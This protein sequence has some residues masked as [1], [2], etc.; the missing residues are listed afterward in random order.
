MDYLKYSNDG[1]RVIGVSSRFLTYVEIPN[2]VTEIGSFA[3][4]GCKSLK[5]VIIPNSVTKIGSYSFDGCESLKSIK[6]PDSVTTIE[7]SAFSGCNNIESV[8]IP[9]S[10]TKIGY[11]AFGYCHRLYNIEI[12][13]SVREIGEYAFDNCQK[14]GAIYINDILFKIKGCCPETVIIQE[15]T[16]IISDGAFANCTTLQNV[17]IPNS[18]EKIGNEAFKGCKSLKSIILPDNIKKIGTYAFNDCTSLKEIVFPESVCMEIGGNAFKNTE[19][20]NNQEDGA[21]YINDVLYRFKES[22]KE[23]ICVVKDGTK[24]I[25]PFAF[26]GCKD[27]QEIVIPDCVTDIGGY[28]FYNCSSLKK[29]FISNNIKR[30]DDYSFYNCTSLES[31]DI[32]NSVKS[33]GESA[34]SGCSSLKIIDIPN[35]IEEIGSKAFFNCTSLTSIDIPNSIKKVGQE[36]FDNTKW[37]NDYSDGVVYLN[38][39]LYTIK[40]GFEATQLTIKEGTTCIAER[41]LANKNSINEI[42]LPNS[43]KCLGKFCLIGCKSLDTIHSHI[44]KPEEVIIEDSFDFSFLN[45]LSLFVPSGTRW[46]YRHHPVFG[47]LSKIEIEEI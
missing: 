37:F 14:N 45:R 11:G 16:R 1:K 17:V 12:P 25:L 20:L 46:S 40:G 18:V 21:L 27:I 5:E 33:I 38:K 26:D 41:A 43:L 32:P 44:L 13:N 19:W 2:G 9:N 42:F 29:I 10:V 7:D 4:S 47:R 23:S 8:V 6:L 30:I 15:G 24:K 28:A 34:F 31:V 3:F 22:A 39:V 35:S 36:A